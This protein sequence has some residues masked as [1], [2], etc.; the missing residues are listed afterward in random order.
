MPDVGQTTIGTFFF[1]VFFTLAPT[2]ELVHFDL[3]V[4]PTQCTD[5]TSN[6][7]ANSVFLDVSACASTFQIDYTLSLDMSQCPLSGVVIYDYSYSVNGGAAIPGSVFDCIGFTG[8]NTVT[9]YI[10]NG[11]CVKEV[12][13]IIDCT[14]VGID[15]LSETEVRIY[16]NPANDVL[17]VEFG[18]MSKL[19]EIEITDLTGRAVVD[20]SQV[21]MVS[22]DLSIP[23]HSLTP[24]TYLIR[25]T[26]ESGSPL[27]KRF[28]KL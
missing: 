6:F 23:L 9:F 21:Q 19:N 2:N 12:T 24:G 20:L 26:T 27:V 16:P 8:V 28:V 14:G 17:H 13:T 7:L 10:D 5:D 18:D 3:Q 22:G 11:V 15:E 1:T 25:I 4:F